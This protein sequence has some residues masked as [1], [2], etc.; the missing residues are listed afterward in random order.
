MLRIIPLETALKLITVWTTYWDFH[1]STGIKK[2]S[3]FI[4]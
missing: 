1:Q 2:D 3:Q 4:W